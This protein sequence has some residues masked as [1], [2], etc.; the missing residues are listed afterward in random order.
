MNKKWMLLAIV[1]LSACGQVDQEEV[2]TDIAANVIEDVLSSSSS[3]AISSVAAQEEPNE[4]PVPSGVVVT[5]VIDGDTIKVRL[6]DGIEESVRIIGIDTPEVRPMQCFGEEA[7]SRM[8]MLVKGKVVELERD[9]ADDRDNFGRLLRYI[10]VDGKDIGASMINDGYAHS[11]TKYPHPR[12][13]HYNVL[14]RDARSA[15]RGLWGDVCEEPDVE[16]TE[17]VVQEDP[18][19]E[20]PPPPEQECNIKGNVNSK[21]EKIYHYPGCRSYK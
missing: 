20:Q 9:P 15:K 17:E 12:M 6:E 18:L 13:E 3:S 1:L 11:Y 5:A 10:S 21:G 4:P 2:P 14:E 19:Q 8:Q 7:T 16:P